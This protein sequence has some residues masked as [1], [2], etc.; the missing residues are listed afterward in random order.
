[1]LHAGFWWHV[2]PKRRL[3]FNGLQGVISQKIRLFP[4]LLLVEVYSDSARFICAVWRLRGDNTYRWTHRRL[5]LA[6]A[7]IRTSLKWHCCHLPGWTD[8]NPHT[9]LLGS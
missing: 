3:T 8:H 9:F 5:I 4:M 6:S 7:G 1:V 2:P